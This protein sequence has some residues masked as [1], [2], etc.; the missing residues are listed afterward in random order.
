MRNP[1]KKERDFRNESPP[2]YVLQSI[3]QYRFDQIFEP[4]S[5]TDLMKQDMS[6]KDVPLEKLIKDIGGSD[7]KISK[8]EENTFILQVSL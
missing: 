6:K 8:E 3:I 5:T 2:N 4:S 7:Q 1:L